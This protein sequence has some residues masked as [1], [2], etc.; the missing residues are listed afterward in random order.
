MPNNVEIMEC[1]IISSMQYVVSQFPLE[2]YVSSVAQYRYG[3]YH[4]ALAYVN[5]HVALCCPSVK[6]KCSKQ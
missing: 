4:P 3:Q 5:L 1:M 6:L 2:Y